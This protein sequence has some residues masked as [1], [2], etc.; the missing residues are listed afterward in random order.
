MPIRL[1]RLSF[2]SPAVLLVLFALLLPAITA[3]LN[4]S[5]EVE[6]FSWLRSWA[7]DRD[8]D[9]TNEYQ[10][11]Y[12]A[13]PLH[14]AGFHETF[15]ERTNENGR[16]S[17]F[18]PVGTALLWAPFFAVGHLAAGLLGE[19]QDG[20]SRP[21]IRAVTIGSACYGLLALMLSQAMASRVLG[22]SAG[23]ATLLV[24]VGTP[25]LFYMYVA[26]GFGHACSAF[27]VSLFLWTWIRIRGRWSLG[28][29][30]Q[31]GLT[32]ALLPMVREQD[33]F[34]LAGPA[35]DWLVWTLAMR[36]PAPNAGAPAVPGRAPARPS[37]RGRDA[38]LFA[39]TGAAAFL[40]LYSVQL[41]AYVALNGHPGP[42][43]MVARKMTWSAPHMVAVLVSSEHGFFVWTPLALAA[44]AGLVWLSLRRT[45][46]P[47][48]PA[49]TAPGRSTPPRDVR[50][51]AL[52][53]LLMCLL[54]A[55]ISGSVESWTVAGSFG[56][57]RFV[58]LTPLL[59]LGTA[60][61]TECWAMTTSRRVTLAALF[62]LCLWWNVGL[63]AQFGLHLMDRQQLTPGDNARITFLELPHRLPSL[64]WRYLF[65]RESFFGLPRQ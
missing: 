31:L 53:A 3:R 37:S 40:L 65:H 24:W 8:A 33:V 51:I 39:L 15:L 7:F 4:A 28:G 2:R 27:A 48:S 46:L 20:Y 17:N 61:L 62:T 41:M 10:H 52:L 19:A 6:F 59:V 23:L 1:R 64:A 34:F 57:R 18:T 11:F 45:G 49:Q 22:A 50:W 26:P 58:A 63:M 43:Q 12:D 56:Q 16:P 38:G 54:Q 14:N 36:T 35:L 47:A 60:A 55:Y 9:F 13:G 42:P 32:G 44:L 25:L 29:A 30:V 5:D 21:Y